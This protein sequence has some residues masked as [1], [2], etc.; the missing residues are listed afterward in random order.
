MYCSHASSLGHQGVAVL[1]LL[2]EMVLFAFDPFCLRTFHSSRS[3]AAGSGLIGGGRRGGRGFTL[4]R[5]SVVGYTQITVHLHLRRVDFHHRSHTIG[6]WGA[7]V[8][9]Q[10]QRRLL[11]V[12]HI[13]GRRRIINSLARSTGLPGRIRTAD[14]HVLIVGA[15]LRFSLTIQLKM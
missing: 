6:S 7:L 13:V 2:M 14:G 3:G 12:T 15:L 11:A 4:V 10:R 1:L 8:A 5:Q 9:Q